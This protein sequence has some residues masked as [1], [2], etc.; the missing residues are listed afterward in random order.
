MFL[1]R[2]D[3][4]INPQPVNATAIREVTMLTGNENIRAKQRSVMKILDRARVQVRVCSHFSFFSYF[5]VI[6]PGSPNYVKKP[7][8]QHLKFAYFSR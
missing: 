2:K 3:G 1:S 5:P 6:F 7:V 4:K 8:K